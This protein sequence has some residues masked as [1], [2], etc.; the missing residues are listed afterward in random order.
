MKERTE[1]TRKRIVKEA[2]ELLTRFGRGS[3]T[4][5][6][7]SSAAEVQP[8][9]IYRLFGD[10]NG[11]LEAVA[12]AGFAD[13]L[14][15]KTTR[16]KFEDPLD[17]LRAGWDLHIDFGLGHPSIYV[18]MYGDPATTAASAVAAAS[19]QVLIGLVQRV[20]EAG[21]LTVPVERAA[22]LIHAAGMGLTLSL[23]AFPP[24]HRDR[25]LADQMREIV[26]AGITVNFERQTPSGVE[27]A[28]H[29]VALGA[30]LDR[31]GSVFSIGERALLSEL[32]NRMARA[33][34][35]T[36]SSIGEVRLSGGAKRAGTTRRP[37]KT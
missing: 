18:L 36:S 14:S 25:T 6:A 22:A 34:S 27:L 11:L 35:S 26:L 23:L 32:L 4:T 21:R 8:P 3:V 2:S 1:Q 12:A 28:Q 9:T 10:M 20:A 17:D 31:T 7:V 16:T 29:A 19:D 13:Y 30:L 5:R 37:P 33:E 15:H 24:E